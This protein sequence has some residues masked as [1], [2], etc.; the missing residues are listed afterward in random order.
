MPAN[1]RPDDV[2][3]AEA[4][5]LL[6]AYYSNTLTPDEERVLFQSAASDQRVFDLLME[7]EVIRDALSSP[8]QR[9]RVV[10]ALRVWNAV[11]ENDDTRK[12]LPSSPGPP[13][14][15]AWTRSILFEANTATSETR[16]FYRLADHEETERHLA[17]PS[18]EGASDGISAGV[19]S[20]R[21]AAVKRTLLILLLLLLAVIVNTA[22]LIVLVKR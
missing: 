16:V 4:A 22:L 3:S 19:L 10:N 12:Q 9:G 7:A 6:N 5:S 11:Q 18:A 15:E 20:W 21:S 13:A 2:A 8:E 17:Q 14:S 1:E